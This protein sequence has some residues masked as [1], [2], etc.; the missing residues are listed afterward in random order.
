MHIVQGLMYVVLYVGIRYLVNTFVGGVV[1]QVFSMGFFLLTLL[2][3][4]RHYV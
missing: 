1:L 2:F 3:S 4:N